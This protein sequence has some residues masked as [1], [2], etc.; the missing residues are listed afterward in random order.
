MS[1]EFQNRFKEMLMLFKENEAEEAA[2]TI[3]EEK[4]IVFFTDEIMRKSLEE[5]GKDWEEGKAALSQIYI[6]GR[7]CENITEKMFEKHPENYRDD[8]KVS[9]AAIEDYHI[10]GKKIVISMIRS[11][12]YKVKDFGH[13]LS[14][15]KIAEKTLEEKPDVL[16]VSALMFPSAKKIKTLTDILRRNS[17]KTKVLVGGAPFLFDEELW[18]EVGA[19]AMGRNGADAVKIIESWHGEDSQET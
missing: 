17:S 13:G 6:A 4:G 12:G 14:A 10:L 11:A 15:E 8:V 3:A 16:C 18:Q 5:I 1:S 7:I 2:Y 9:A 19:D